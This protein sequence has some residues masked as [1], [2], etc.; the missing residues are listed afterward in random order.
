MGDAMHLHP[1]M[2]LNP[3]GDHLT[4]FYIGLESE[5]K[6]GSSNRS[7]SCF[8]SFIDEGKNVGRDW[9][10]LKLSYELK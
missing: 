3:E 4:S 7:L 6:R 10:A 8:Y 2:H 9:C 5:A 1:K